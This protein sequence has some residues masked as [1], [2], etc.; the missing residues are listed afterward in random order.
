MQG[1]KDKSHKFIVALWRGRKK[2]GEQNDSKSTKV[3]NSESEA[4]E[5]ARRSLVNYPSI[6]L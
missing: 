6:S 4:I 1:R 2:I 5:A 3:K